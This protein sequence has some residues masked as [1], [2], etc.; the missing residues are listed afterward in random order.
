MDLAF[1]GGT[2]GIFILALIVFIVGL[3][4]FLRA[5]FRSKAEKAIEEGLEGKDYASPL[6]ARNKYPEVNP[7]YLSRPI[8][9]FGLAA[10]LLVILLA[11]SWTRFEKEI[12][13]PEGALEWEEE[14]EIEPP[15][16][17][18]IIQS[19]SWANSVVRP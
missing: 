17:T 13:I 9:L 1:E 7:F 6:V 19:C 3:I 2:I 12:Y 4:F 16:Q 15:I 8:W 18:L 5:R 11:F 14:I 10:S